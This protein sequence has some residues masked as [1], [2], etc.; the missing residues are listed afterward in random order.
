V[1]EWY[2]KKRGGRRGRVKERGKV[3]CGGGIL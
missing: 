2:N 3:N 1:A